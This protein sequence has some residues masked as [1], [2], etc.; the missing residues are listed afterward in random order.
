EELSER[1]HPR[2]RVDLHQPDRTCIG[3]R[4]RLEVAVLDHQD[5]ADERRWNAAAIRFAHGE[6]RNGIGATRRDVRR[7]HEI[8]LERTPVDLEL[9]AH[10]REVTEARCPWRARQW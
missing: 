4:G 1:A 2:A 3:L 7:A 6:C 10:E 9:R 8:F 5:A